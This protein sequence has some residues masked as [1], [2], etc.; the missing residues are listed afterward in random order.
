MVVYIQS[1]SVDFKDTEKMSEKILCIIE[2]TV[3]AI[4][5]NSQDNIYYGGVIYIKYRKKECSK[6]LL[7]APM[8][9]G[10]Y[11]LIN[12]IL[13]TNML[14]EAN[15]ATTAVITRIKDEDGKLNMG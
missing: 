6:F 5:L 8:S 15:K 12:S 9:S 2:W 1:N 3:F 11:T 13:G 4:W 14:L 7:I 10:K